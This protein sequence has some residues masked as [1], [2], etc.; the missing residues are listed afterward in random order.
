MLSIGKL[1]KGQERYYLSKVAEGQEDYYSGEGEEAGQWLGDAAAE[2]GLSG[3]VSP[4]A[5]ST[6]G[7][8]AWPAVSRPPADELR[9]NSLGALAIQHAP[10]ARASV[11]HLICA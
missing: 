2:L 9:G 3:E 5:A 8:G 11:I 7:T 4:A 6:R 10:E 1:G